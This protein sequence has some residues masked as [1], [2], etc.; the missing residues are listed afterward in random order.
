MH[1]KAG[2]WSGAPF[3]G[4]RASLWTPSLGVNS[5]TGIFLKCNVVNVVNVDQQVLFCPFWSHGRDTFDMKLDSFEACQTK[6]AQLLRVLLKLTMAF[7][8][9][10]SR[11][12]V[13][14]GNL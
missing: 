14:K 7:R 8:L 11:Y 1:S 9:L 6:P 2:I 13:A 10:G 12:A 4:V 5:F 3:G